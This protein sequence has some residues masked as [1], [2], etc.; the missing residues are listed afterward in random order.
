[1]SWGQY[2]QIIPLPAPV[3]G[4]QMKIDQLK[5]ELLI[6]LPKA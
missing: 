1:M 6:T 4:E 5:H 2:A 3:K